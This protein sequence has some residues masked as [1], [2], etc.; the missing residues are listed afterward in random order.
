MHRADV[1]LDVLNNSDGSTLQAAWKESVNE[2]AWSPRGFLTRTCRIK[3]WF[4]MNFPDGTSG[5]CGPHR[6]NLSMGNPARRCSA[7]EIT[8]DDKWQNS[9][10]YGSRF[11][12]GRSS[13][14]SPFFCHM[15]PLIAVS[16]TAPPPSPSPTFFFFLLPNNPSLFGWKTVRWKS[17]T[18]NVT[19]AGARFEQNKESKRKKKTNRH[20]LRW[21]QMKSR[22]LVH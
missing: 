21:M 17:G 9:S 5:R 14:C 2:R 12:P 3:R 1:T 19:V 8:R 18:G 6:Q 10:T 4:H 20:L 11:K 15:V 7:A 13:K 22:G 16:P